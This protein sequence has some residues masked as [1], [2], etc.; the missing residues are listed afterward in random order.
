VRDRAVR[1]I[2]AEDPYAGLLI[3]MHTYNLLTTRAD[4]STIA[5]DGLLLLDAFLHLQREY[6]GELQAA[7]AADASLDPSEVSEQTI[8]EHFR[9]LQACDNLSLLT[10]VAFSLP[11]DLLHPLPLN[12]GQTAQVNV[13][14]MAPRR[15]RLVPW[16]FA[17]SELSF[18]F[19]A[20]HVKG[21][22]FSSSQSLEAARPHTMLRPLNSWR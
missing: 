10:C 15:F 19:P 11:A 17:K 14:P 16:P 8:L 18:T 6:Q 9:L 22:L 2:A 1:I 5:R 21:K 7:I 3:S 4:R 13:L 12:N 20:R